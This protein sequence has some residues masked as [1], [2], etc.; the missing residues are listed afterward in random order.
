MGK[1]AAFYFTTIFLAIAGL[2]AIIR[3][4]S[5]LRPPRDISG[6]W[7]MTTPTNG[8]SDS[9]MAVELS[10]SGRYL[11]VHHPNSKPMSLV[12]SSTDDNTDKPWRMVFQSGSQQLII[13]QASIAAEQADASWALF[14]FQGNLSQTLLGQRQVQDRPPTGAG[15]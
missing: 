13:E 2:W 12:L 4:G 1:A 5:T 11:L 14:H 3:Y 9:P 7:M 6:R 8:P 15:H 10:Q